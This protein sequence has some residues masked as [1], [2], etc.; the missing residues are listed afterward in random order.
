MRWEIGPILQIKIALS[1]IEQEIKEYIEH[2]YT[3]FYGI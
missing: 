2:T 3:G 1:Q